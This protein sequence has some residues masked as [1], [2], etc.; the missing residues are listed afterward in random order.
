VGPSRQILGQK[1]HFLTFNTRAAAPNEPTFGPKNLPAPVLN[2]ITTDVTAAL[3]DPAV[4]KQLEDQGLTPRPI[5]GAAF[6]KF[7]ASEM[8]KY[9]PIIK[10]ANI[11][12]E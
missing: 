2:K 10:G 4:V 5:S 12:A 11:R 9:A 1:I 3:K 7:I 6:S 8:S